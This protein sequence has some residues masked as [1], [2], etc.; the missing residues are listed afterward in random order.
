[1]LCGQTAGTTFLPGALTIANAG[2][3]VFSAGGNYGPGYFCQE[4]V[5]S[6]SSTPGNYEA[7]FGYDRQVV[8][9]A[10]FVVGDELRR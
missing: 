5:M 9:S 3:V 8:A 2:K 7:R 4:V 6:D 1:M 10:K